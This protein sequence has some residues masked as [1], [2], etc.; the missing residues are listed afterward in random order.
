MMVQFVNHY[1]GIGEI[2][3]E[4][5]VALI[6]GTRVF[7]EGHIRI[8]RSDDRRDTII[9]NS[10]KEFYGAYAA[11]CILHPLSD[12][13]SHFLDAWS[14]VAMLGEKDDDVQ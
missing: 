14:Y 6:G 10:K 1:K 7:Q 8:R 9:F 13:E 3:M 5:H 2:T 11:M 12:L 4:V